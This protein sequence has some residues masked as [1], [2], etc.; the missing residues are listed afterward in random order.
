MFFANRSNL[1]YDELR[2]YINKLRDEPTVKIHW[3]VIDTALVQPQ[4]P[5]NR[6]C[7]QIADALASSFFSALEYTSWGFTESRFAEML[8]PVIYS[9]NG[10]YLS[11]GLK[12]FPR[13]P[14]E[15]RNHEPRFDWVE[16]HYK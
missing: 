2:N 9:R 12:F 1:S 4:Q 11:Y 13:M 5:R 7:L 6:I 14:E 8:K 16:M 15:L 3:P 10:N